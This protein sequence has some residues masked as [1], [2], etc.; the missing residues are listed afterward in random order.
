[1]AGKKLDTADK[2]TG[3]PLRV[4]VKCEKELL[5]ELEPYARWLKV[6]EAN[7]TLAE[8]AG[9]DLRE[10]FSSGVF[11]WAIRQM[12]G[13]IERLIEEGKQL[14][15]DHFLALLENPWTGVPR[16]EDT[17][18]QAFQQAEFFIPSHPSREIVPHK[19]WPRLWRTYITAVTI[20]ERIDR[21][22]WRNPAARLLAYKEK[23]PGLSEGD[24]Q[25]ILKLKKRSDRA[26]ACVRFQLKLSVGIEALQ[27]Y[28]A[29]TFHKD[30]RYGFHDFLVFNLERIKK[31]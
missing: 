9:R 8:L 26:L 6:I 2:P 20:L 28:F 11:D 3:N 15:L 1:M 21:K 4:F 22:K 29:K 30:P 25:K 23:F 12:N 13:K 16:N 7:E 10:K 31:G 5:Q 27:K 17:F 14:Y 19:E 24:I 18:W